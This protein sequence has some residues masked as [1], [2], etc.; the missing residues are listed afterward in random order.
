[1]SKRLNSPFDSALVLARGFVL[2]FMAQQLRNGRVSA[3]SIHCSTVRR[4]HRGARLMPSLYDQIQEAKVAIQAKYSGR[5]RV[6]IILGTGLGGLVE[7]IQ[8][9]A[10]FPYAEIPHFPVSTA[11]GHVSRLVCG[12]LGGKPVM[13]MEGRF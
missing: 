6:G 8:A 11:P 1:M 12:K 2:V 4:N 7:E 10:V 3:L 5:P 13:A 9:E